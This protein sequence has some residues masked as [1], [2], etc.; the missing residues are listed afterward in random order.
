VLNFPSFDVLCVVW[1]GHWCSIDSELSH[2]DLKMST[3]SV[4]WA[5]LTPPFL[6]YF[7]ANSASVT[8]RKGLIP[9]RAKC[10]KFRS[11][12]HFVRKFSLVVISTV[13]KKF[14][15]TQ[16]FDWFRYFVIQNTSIWLAS[17]FPFH[18]GVETNSTTRRREIFRR[19]TFQNN[20][21]C[22]FNLFAR[23]FSHFARLGIGP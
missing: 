15:K 5:F 16:A 3:G 4:Q 22:A 23:N 8:P 1:S 7:F 14:A 18:N 12:T 17:L 13:E 10:E 11:K 6:G 21:A 19:E 20:V 9:R 2:S